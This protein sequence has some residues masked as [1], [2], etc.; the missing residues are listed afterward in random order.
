MNLLVNVGKY[1]NRLVKLSED[2]GRFSG[3]F[4]GV[5]PF[6]PNADEVAMI[7]TIR[8]QE[9]GKKVRNY[10]YSH[11]E[12]HSGL[13]MIEDWLTRVPEYHYQRY[14]INNVVEPV[15]YFDKNGTGKFEVIDNLADDLAMWDFVNFLHEEKEQIIELAGVERQK[16]KLD[17]LGTPAQLGFIMKELA[18][19]GFIKIPQMKNGKPNMSAFER[20]ILDCFNGDFGNSVIR[21]AITDGTDSNS[22]VASNKAKFTFPHISE[23]T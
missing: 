19:K 13:E 21:Q 6:L 20:V 23:L 9:Y 15:S 8:K 22:L 2:K 5:E 16:L 1:F 7:E 3:R 14:Y 11:D 10:F 18:D 4:V 12:V 17:W